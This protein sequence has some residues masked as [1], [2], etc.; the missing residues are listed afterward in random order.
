MRQ[1]AFFLGLG[2]QCRFC[3]ATWPQ[4]T[5]RGAVLHVPPFAEELN[6]SRRMAALAAQAMARA[7]WLV[8]QIDHHGCGD[9]EGDFA[10]ATWDS[11]LHDLDT[12]HG[13][14]IEQ[15]TGPICLWTL[16]AGSLLAASWLSGRA[17]ARPL[18]MV[19]WQPVINGGQYLTQFLRIRLANEMADGA[20]A[21]TLMATLRDDLQAGR[22]ALVA[23][24]PLSSAVA[25]GLESA[26]LT[27][28]S[29]HA[30]PI[31]LLEVSPGAIPVLTPATQ[32]LL[33][34]LQKLG[35]PREAAAVSGPKFWQT[36]EIEVAPALIAPTM[37]A[38]E[39]ASP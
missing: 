32:Q 15:T 7:G 6:R 26:V 38:F 22:P 14:L 16:R 12:A 27:M 33:H 18:P 29:N 23:G 13:W 35:M 31:T 25:R 24:Y 11:W 1:E 30:A 34:T 19:C 5:P 9:S 17:Q 36:A 2:A 4:G 3:L 21:R 20:A 28:V 10:D 8:L 37:A 39:A